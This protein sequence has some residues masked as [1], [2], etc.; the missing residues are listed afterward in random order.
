MKKT[1][2][3]ILGTLLTIVV[4][5]ITQYYIRRYYN[6]DSRIWLFVVYGI[7]CISVCVVFCIFY[8]EIKNMK[9][10]FETHSFSEFAL[11]ILEKTRL[12][13]EKIIKS[14][15]YELLVY[16]IMLI[17]LLATIDKIFFHIRILWQNYN[18]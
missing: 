4:F 1:L 18:I 13:T 12:I 15:W 5:I 16:I 14:F 2:C 17:V 3:K 8:S 11:E 6:I 7:S 10:Y 9:K